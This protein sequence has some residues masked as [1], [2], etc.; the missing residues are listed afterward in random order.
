MSL[1]MKHRRCGGVAAAGLAREDERATAGVDGRGMDQH[2]AALMEG[3]RE[4]RPKGV[5]GEV[6]DGVL[7]RRVDERDSARRDEE[8]RAVRKAGQKR[9]VVRAADVDRFALVPRPEGVAR[10]LPRA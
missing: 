4:E 8:C 7:A 1:A 6:V 9:A 2:C 5:G 3:E 10:L